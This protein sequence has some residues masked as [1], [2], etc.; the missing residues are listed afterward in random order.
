MEQ[1]E[2]WLGIDKVEH[3]LACML[4]TILVSVLVR[5]SRRPFLRR[6]SVAIGS[7]ASLVVG[8]AKEAADEIGIWK[9]SGASL[10]DAAADAL[11]VVLAAAILALAG[12]ILSYGHGRYGLDRKLK[13]RLLGLD[14]EIFRL[15]LQPTLISALARIGLFALIDVAIPLGNTS[16]DYSQTLLFQVSVNHVSFVADVSSHYGSSLAAEQSHMESAPVARRLTVA[17][18][19]DDKRYGG[20]LWNQVL[21]RVVVISMTDCWP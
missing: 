12:R 5:R 10:R 14:H 3:L 7:I 18:L 16:F 17:R 6:W 4:I 8:A 19:N 9:S 21:G 13:E 20:R 15:A 2:P 11:G 1:G